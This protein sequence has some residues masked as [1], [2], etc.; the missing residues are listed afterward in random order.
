MW[1][2]SASVYIYHPIVF[3]YT[4]TK[5]LL[6]ILA[7]HAQ[8]AWEQRGAAHSSPVSR[9]ADMLRMVLRVGIVT[10][11]KSTLTLLIIRNK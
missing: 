11:C 10:G 9:S 8:Q 4:Y 1:N 5:E 7:Q 2:P 3:H 6:C